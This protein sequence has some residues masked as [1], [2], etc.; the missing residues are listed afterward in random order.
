MSSVQRG[1]Y[2]EDTAV[3]FLQDRDYLIL[4]RNVRL[5]RYEVDVVAQKDNTIIFI[6]IKARTNE[7]F[8]KGVEYVTVAKQKK[9]IRTA[10]LYLKQHSLE[11]YLIRFDV[12]SITLDST[13]GTAKKIEHYINAFEVG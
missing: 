3:R 10:C 1:R 7:G 2:G 13:N 8:G 12:I 4:D 9:L 6:E 5:L 11:H